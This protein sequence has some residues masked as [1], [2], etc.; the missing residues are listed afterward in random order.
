MIMSS[1][2]MKITRMRLLPAAVFAPQDEDQGLARKSASGG[3]ITMGSQA[4]LFALSML[5]TVVLARL[6]TP[7]DFGLISMVAVITGFAGMFK[8]AGL[9]L[10]TVTQGQ[11]TPAQISNLFWTNALI[12]TGLG[13]C[14][15]LGS[16][17]VASFYSQPELAAITAALAVPFVISGLTI[18]HQALLRRQMRFGAL[19]VIHI[20][21]QVVSLA[22]VTMLAWLGWRYWALVAGSVLEALCTLSLALFFCPWVPGRIQKGVGSR[23][24]FAFG[25]HI[26][27]FNFVNYFSRNLDNILIGRY[28]GA[29]A[30]GLYSRAY[31]LFMLPFSKVRGPMTE[32]AMPALSRLREQPKRFVAYFRRYLDL[33]A[34]VIVPIVAYSILEADF[35]IGTLLGDQWLDA[36][37]I[38]KILAVAGLVQAIA[39]FARGLTLIPFGFTARYLRWGVA[40]SVVKVISFVVGLRYGVIGI[41]AAYAITD[42]IVLIP[43]LLYSFKGTPVRLGMFF[44]SLAAPS[45]I[46]VAAVLIALGMR[47]ALPVDATGGHLLVLAVT[48]S[49]YVG[50][51]LCREPVRETITLVAV[52]LRPRRE[53]RSLKSIAGQCR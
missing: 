28:I 9:S 44:Q 6:L 12:S 31:S 46:T 16:P 29:D 36:V 23:R 38:F 49:S 18:Q 33:V 21:T 35:V 14:I 25:G 53:R 26:A 41:A 40:N 42:L 7:G 24:M 19:A 39:S 17:L 4:V 27:A 43:S 10:A 15:L 52:R 8:D 45:A 11:I 48:G 22:M 13:G 47:F 3:I 32:V 20:A 37:P 5:R 2:A 1:V 30:L 51:S 50:L 34:T